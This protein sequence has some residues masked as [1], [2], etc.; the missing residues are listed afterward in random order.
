MFSAGQRLV[1]WSFFMEVLPIYLFP[2][3]TQSTCFHVTA[4]VWKNTNNKKH[5]TGCSQG[6]VIIFIPQYVA[7]TPYRWC[8]SQ[9]THR[10]FFECC[11]YRSCT[12]PVRMTDGC[13]TDDVNSKERKKEIPWIWCWTVVKGEDS[14]PDFFFSLSTQSQINTHFLQTFF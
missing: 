14:L 12:V 5:T 7:N 1:M 8:H 3:L 10:F 13:I 6:H 2:R 9:N 4:V 11:T